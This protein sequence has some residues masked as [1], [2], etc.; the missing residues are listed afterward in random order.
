MKK[1]FLFL[2]IFFPFIYI[3]A[4]EKTELFQVSELNINFVSDDGNG[5][6]T[7]AGDGENV[8]DGEGYLAIRHS[9][10][11]IEEK[12]FLSNYDYGTSWNAKVKSACTINGTT[13]ASGTVAYSTSDVW[14]EVRKYNAGESTHSAF[15]TI[16]NTDI[17]L[18]S[19]GGDLYASITTYGNSDTGDWNLELDANYLVKINQDDL[20]LDWVYKLPT[21]WKIKWISYLQNAIDRYIIQSL[22]NGNIAVKVLYSPGDWDDAKWELW[23]FDP[24]DGHNEGTILTGFEPNPD[25]P[26]GDSVYLYRYHTWKIIDGKIYDEKWDKYD[27]DDD[28]DGH[29]TI[30]ETE[31]PYD[32]VPWADKA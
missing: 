26:N 3:Q 2:S 12:V 31:D 15:H 29:M 21:D 14:S 13:F 17:L 16:K 19:S 23:E 7:I 32:G 10:G 25:D 18:I 8:D 24:A 6:Y 5:V 11:S 22:P 27:D 28:E 9:G 1:N 20:S 30:Y 4:Q